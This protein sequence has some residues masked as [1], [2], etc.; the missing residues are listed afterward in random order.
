MK[1]NPPFQ[2]ICVMGNSGSGKST[3]ANALS[4]KYQLP[5]F[6][7]DRELLYGQFNPHPLEKQLA[8]H[9]KIIKQDKWVI[10][11]AY[12]QLI[13]AR[14]KRAELVIFLNISRKT[15]IPRVVKRYI[16]NTNREHTVPSEA[17][18]ALSLNFLFIL[19]K[20]SR[21]KKLQTLQET[22][23]Q[24]HP[25]LPLLVL[26]KDTLEHWLTAV[27]KFGAR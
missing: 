27:E 23:K 10:D 13:P 11:G 8:I 19:L 2:R 24:E 18:N 4:E 6:H 16:F 15:I 1:T 14:I 5:A 21:K 9:D 20:H 22:I 3:L 17:K 25:G 26:N 7:L 12:K